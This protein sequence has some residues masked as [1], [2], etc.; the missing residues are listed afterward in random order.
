V[1]R[2]HPPIPKIWLMTDERLGEGLWRAI[3][4]LPRGSGIVFRHYATAVAERRAVFRRVIRMARAR[5]LIVLRAGDSCGYGEMGTHGSGRRTGG[6]RTMPAHSRAEAMAAMRRG[7]DAVFVSPVFATESHPGA[8][9]LG[10]RGAQRIAQGLP[11]RA[12]A[13]GGMDAQRFRRMQGFYGWAAI[14]AW[15]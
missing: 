5:G 3:E 2:R 9:S 13:L 6:L 4:R 7:A 12:I 10:V 8:S 1:L 15:V 11:V 14:G